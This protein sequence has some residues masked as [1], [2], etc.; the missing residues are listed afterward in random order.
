MT[1]TPQSLSA[2]R[3]IGTRGRQS[4]RTPVAEEVSRRKVPDL[5]P[6]LAVLLDRSNV[7]VGP[8]AG[9][10]AMARAGSVISYAPDARI[11]AEALAA[12]VDFFVTRDQ[13]HFLDNP[14]ARDLPCLVG[15]PGDALNWL[16]E[17][18]APA[19]MMAISLAGR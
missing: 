18:L 19:R 6:A 17:R 4:Y 15:S 16:Y 1:E 11:L 13:A 10:S 7:Q 9:A 12:E 14:N 8:G 3:P 5:L 2:R